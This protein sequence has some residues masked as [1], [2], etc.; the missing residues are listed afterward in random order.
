MKEKKLT[1]KEQRFIRHYLETGNGAEAIK[2][3]KYQLGSHG[4]K[5]GRPRQQTASS[6]AVELMNKPHIR[7]AWQ[8]LYVKEE[9]TPERVLINLNKLSQG[10]QKESDQIRANELLG[11]HLKLF[12]DAAVQVDSIQISLGNTLQREQIDKVID[13]D[14]TD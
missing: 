6:M 7:K 12:S 3:A 9:I 8:K 2:L 11:K 13:S 10:A 5:D 14:N 4:G 1:L